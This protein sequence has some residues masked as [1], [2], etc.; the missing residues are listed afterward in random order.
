MWR[1]TIASAAA[2]TPSVQHIVRTRLR[3]KTPASHSVAIPLPNAPVVKPPRA[4]V[5]RTTVEVLS[6]AEEEMVANMVGLCRKDSYGRD[7][8]TT[9]V[10]LSSISILLFTS[11]RMCMDVET[12]WFSSS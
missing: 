8:F 1:S 4:V 7:C 3:G 2:E 12:V 9:K 6:K 11:E 5:K 10:R